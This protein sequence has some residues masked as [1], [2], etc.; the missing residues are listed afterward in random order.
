MSRRP[1]DA[2]GKPVSHTRIHMFR[3][4]T[5]APANR[6]TRRI[7]GA[8]VAML[9]LTLSACSDSNPT[10]PDSKASRSGYLTISAAVK[11]NA[12]INFSAMYPS[13]SLQL[14]VKSKSLK[15][16]TTYQKFT[17]N[18]TVGSLI[19]FGTS[20][21]DVIAIPPGSLCDPKTNTYGP[22]EWK[23]PCSIAVSTITFE[24][25]SWVDAEQHPHAEFYP[26]MRFNPSAVTPVTLFFQDPLM[27]NYTQVRIPYC[28]A[29]NVCVDEGATDPEL[30]TYVTPLPY[31]GY[32]VYRKLRH[33][34]G[35][36][37]TAY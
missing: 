10:T 14:P 19:V 11:T 30:E 34:S 15:G 5:T 21:N 23:K 37:V 35:Y 4:R 25:R 2:S 9:A 27:V 31:G 24:I 12:I 16:D 6:V 1:H 28:N 7:L 8:A 22:T 17:V 13:M 36:N 20:S 33:F 18:P 29:A 26:A 3:F 32:Y